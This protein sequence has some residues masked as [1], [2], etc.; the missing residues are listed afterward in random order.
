MLAAVKARGERTVSNVRALT[1]MT[2][3]LRNPTANPGG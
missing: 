3:S 1:L 2:V